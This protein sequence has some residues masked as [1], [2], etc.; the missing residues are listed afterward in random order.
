MTVETRERTT[1]RNLLVSGLAGLAAAAAAMIGRPMGARAEGQAMVVG[2][3]YTDATT[4]TTLSSQGE[5]NPTMFVEN[6]GNKAALSARSAG[7]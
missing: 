4:T 2:G 7:R 1:R 3:D 6:K 5:A